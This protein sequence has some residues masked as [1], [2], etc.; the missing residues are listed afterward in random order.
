MVELTTNRQVQQETNNDRQQNEDIKH[1]P[2]RTVCTVS[3]P[4]CQQNSC[5]VG[6]ALPAMLVYGAPP[7]P[8]Q[9]RSNNAP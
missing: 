6:F 2:G 8:T 9:D 4:V 3:V 7:H 1:R 5:K